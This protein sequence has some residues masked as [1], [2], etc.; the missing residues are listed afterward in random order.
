[1]KYFLLYSQ[2]FSGH[3]FCQVLHRITRF[4]YYHSH[5][6]IFNKNIEDNEPLSN[7]YPWIPIILAFFATAIKLSSIVMVPMT[8]IAL[9]FHMLKRK[10]EIKLNINTLYHASTK[11]ISTVPRFCLFLIILI[12]A[13][14]FIRGIIIS[15]N[16]FFPISIK[17]S[18]FPWSISIA[19]TQA[20]ANSVTAWARS[21]GPHYLDSL[22]SLSWIHDWIIRFW[23]NQ[24]LFIILTL[25]SIIS[26]FL[27][28]FFTG[29]RNNDEFKKLDYFIY[30]YPFLFIIVGLVFGSFRH[31]N[32]D[33]DWDIFIHCQFFCLFIL[34]IDKRPHPQWLQ[35]WKVILVIGFLFLPLSL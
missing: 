14:F 27:I 31:R 33:L 3:Y 30:L 7:F 21:P 17:N 28:Y 11:I 10:S 9:I 19:K 2:Y 35:N 8:L 25:I 6:W 1:M 24:S 32:R 15:G 20:E 22:N 13:P 23:N 12:I 34:F 4:Y 5:L 29:A 26:F 18:F 16:P